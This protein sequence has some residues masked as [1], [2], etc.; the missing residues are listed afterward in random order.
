MHTIFINVSHICVRYS[1]TFFFMKQLI[2]Y[3][4]ILEH[5]AHFLLFPQVINQ[6]HYLLCIKN[7]VFFISI[8]FFLNIPHI[9]FW[10]AYKSLS[11]LFVKFF[12]YSFFI[13]FI[14]FVCF[15]NTVFSILL[16]CLIYWT[17][18]F[19]FAC[20]AVIVCLFFA[21]LCSAKSPLSLSVF[22]LNFHNSGNEF[23]I[24]WWIHCH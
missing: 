9:L 22:Q 8:L 24:S 12:Q 11:I 10:T 6:N 17:Y 15:C 19:F 14:L 16:G 5:K 18:A 1:P 23:S 3:W 7:T 21:L 2:A 13:G 4:N 20:N